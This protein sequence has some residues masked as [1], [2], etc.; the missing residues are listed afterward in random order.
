MSKP[1][2]KKNWVSLIAPPMFQDRQIGETLVSEPALLIGK[3]IKVNFAV[4]SD[5]MKK[6]STEISFVV[7]KVEGNKA[8]TS[9]LGLRL[10]PTMVRRIVKK[11][12]S[13]I[14]EVMNAVT[15]DKKVVTI[16]I[17]IV[18]QKIV[19]GSVTSK[20]H[21][22][23]IKLVSKMAS[24]TDYV[25]FCEDIVKGSVMKETKEKIKKIYP[26][27]SCE[28]ISFSLNKDQSATAKKPKERKKI[29]EPAEED[30]PE[31]EE[32]KKDSSQ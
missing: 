29:E 14:D 22:E 25:Q 1:I 16:K 5:D 28:V 20:I 15:K 27:K 4:F 3:K 12:R 21:S 13:R 24:Q 32:Q 10:M 17:L 9:F 7:D 26:I 31:E 6:Q 19:R 8:F 18:T 23:V 11:G 30:I 2:S